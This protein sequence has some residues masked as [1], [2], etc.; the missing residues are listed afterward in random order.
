[1]IKIKNNA[2]RE[3]K[4]CYMTT[5]FYSQKLSYKMKFIKNAIFK[6]AIWIGRMP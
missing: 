3:V 1:M 6:N 2:S 4:N 5:F